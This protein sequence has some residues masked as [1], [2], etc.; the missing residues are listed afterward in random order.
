MEQM[1]R[2]YHCLHKREIKRNMER[3]EGLLCGKRYHRIVCFVRNLHIDGS[4]QKD[5]FDRS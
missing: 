5:A 2:T 3:D 1:E 4:Q